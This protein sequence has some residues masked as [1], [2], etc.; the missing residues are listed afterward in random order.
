M[1]LPKSFWI[2]GIKKVNYSL[3]PLRSPNIRESLPLYTFN[4]LPPDLLEGSYYCVPLPQQ[5]CSYCAGKL[6]SILTMFC[7]ITCSMKLTFLGLGFIFFNSVLK[8]AMDEIFDDRFHKYVGDGSI[9]LMQGFWI[10]T[11]E[12]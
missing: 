2:L 9:N 8:N 1:S 10:F 3:D 6:Q 11:Q 12:S 7:C 4:T 5:P